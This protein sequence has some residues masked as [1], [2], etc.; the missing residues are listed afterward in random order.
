MIFE[1]KFS[2]P[3]SATFSMPPVK[4]FIASYLATAIESADPFAGRACLAT[5]NNDLD[6]ASP[7]KFHMEAGDFVAEL[8]RRGVQLDLALFDPPYSPR[9]ISECYKRVGLACGMRETQNATLYKRVRDGLHRILKSGGV[10]LSFGWNSNG[11]GKT[12]GYEL[13]RLLLVHHGGAHN[14]T[15]CLAERKP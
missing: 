13:E 12:R 11:M 4:E 7:A 10:V 8:E 9:Q 1:R 6:L 5:Y 2:M 15:I 3:N 14:D